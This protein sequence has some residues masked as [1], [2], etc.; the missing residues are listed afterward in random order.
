M[1]AYVINLDRDIKKWDTFK[2][3]W[4]NEK[5]D[6]E[7]ISATDGQKLLQSPK[8]KL[9][10]LC[11]LFCTPKMAGCFASHK[12]CWQNV[13]DHNLPY[14]VILED[15]AIPTSNFSQLG[16][17]LSK[18]PSDW[19]L[20]YIGYLNYSGSIKGNSLFL[21]EIMGKVPEKISD[22]VFKPGVVGSAHGYLVS[23]K[24]AK[25]LQKKFKKINFSNDVVVNMH[26]DIIIY[27]SD[28]PLVAT[29]DFRNPFEPQANITW[30]LNDQF[31][32]VCGFTL[33]VGHLVILLVLCITL[34]CFLKSYKPVIVSVIV[35]MFLLFILVIMPFMKN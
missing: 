1:K 4:E 9:T 5:L 28:P 10:N 19:D 23:Q 3:N 29:C 35:I 22:H 20:F 6:F 12:Q 30:L 31:L 7:K 34:S 32:N 13:I 17:F 27:G 21:N 24:G 25:K 15:D 8:H 2:Q 11:Q 16:S 26:K 33:K 14:A 18:V